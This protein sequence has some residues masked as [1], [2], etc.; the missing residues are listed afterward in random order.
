ML[1]L[2]TMPIVLV[3]TLFAEP[4]I[5]KAQAKR[6]EEDERSHRNCRHV[7]FLLAGRAAITQPLFWLIQQP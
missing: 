2:F 4:R 7:F 3:F 5:G 6:L 1:I